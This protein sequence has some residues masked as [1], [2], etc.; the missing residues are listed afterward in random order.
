MILLAPRAT[1]GGGG[2]AKPAT[3]S[4]SAAD[5]NATTSDSTRRIAELET[6]NATLTGA[7]QNTIQENND[8]KDWRKSASAHIDD[9]ENTIKTLTS[10]NEELKA[11]QNQIDADEKE[12][13]ARMEIGLTREQAKAA[14]DR[15][16]H[17]Q[18]VN[19]PKRDDL[20]K[21]RIAAAAK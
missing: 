9:Q 1:E 6:M 16:R 19:Q 11:K 3:E 12:I 7:N 17:D 20:R 14:I 21:A 4:A 5:A 10:E 18:K 13:R 8:L 15:N 2:G